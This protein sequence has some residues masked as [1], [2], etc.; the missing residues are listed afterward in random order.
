MFLNFAGLGLKEGWFS[1]ANTR[2]DNGQPRTK[3]DLG[4]TVITPN[5]LSTLF[6]ADITLP[7]VVTS[8]A[9]GAMFAQ[10]TMPKTSGLFGK[11]TDSFRS[12]ALNLTP[13]LDHHGG[14]PIGD[15][16]PDARGL[17]TG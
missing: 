10:K 12:T 2:D 17:L 11:V 4:R 7:C 16:G 13:S 15:H 9:I 5:A 3:F 1:T 14:G 6:P 8:A